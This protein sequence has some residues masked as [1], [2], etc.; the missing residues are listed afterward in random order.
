MSFKENGGGTGHTFMKSQ[1]TDLASKVR[2]AIGSKTAGI[3]LALA[4][5]A[6]AAIGFWLW[7]QGDGL[8]EG[9][10][11]SNGRIEADQVD[12]SAKLAGRVKEITAREGDLVQPG[13]VLAHMD[14]AEPDAR[15]EKARAEA[16]RAESQ[17]VEARATVD[18]REAQLRLA[19]QELDRTLILVEKG[20]VS[21]GVRDERQSQYDSAHAAL[22]ATRAHLVTAGRA[23]ESAQAEVKRIQTEIDDAVLRAPVMGRVLYRLAEPGEVLSAG[24]KVLTLLNLGEVYMEVFLPSRQAG[25]IALGSD[26]RIVLDPVP[27][28]AIPAT[29]TFVSPQAQFTPKQVETSSEREKLM[30]RIKLKVPSELV[31]KHIE[32]V[33]TGVRG[34]AY[35][36]LAGIDHAPWPAF[37]ERRPPDGNE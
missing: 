29:V 8:P 15:I 34:V 20:H 14:T 16:S 36:R 31:K 24:G 25:R 23:V 22:M 26:A 18:Q 2:S 13:E 12:I 6:A 28:F 11:M 3:A 5:A 30:F 1:M 17:V 32:K 21:K 4:L 7:N 33:K 27:H 10:V 37:L 19:K 9:I 35:L